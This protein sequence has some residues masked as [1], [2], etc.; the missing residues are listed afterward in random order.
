MHR[1]ERRI[2]A[3]IG[4]HK[5]H[6]G[7]LCSEQLEPRLL[8]TTLQADSLG[9]PAYDQEIQASAYYAA[10]SPNGTE[11]DGQTSII[12]DAGTGS[13][14]V[15]A[16][17]GV[18]LSSI[19]IESTSGVFTREPAEN[20]GGAFDVDNDTNIFKAIFGGSFGSLS[21]GNVAPPLLEEAFLLEDLTVRGTLANAG[22]LRNVDLIY[23]RPGLLPNGQIGDEQTSIIYHADSGRLEVDAPSQ[24]ELSGINIV[25]SSGIFAAA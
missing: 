2:N 23:L 9:E 17:A 13:F 11:G 25:S 12:Y 15:D 3:R 18:D 10:V 4:F 14:A 19:D 6:R 20:L 7:T 5:R 1:K 24:R 8:L 22:M 21:F 16:P